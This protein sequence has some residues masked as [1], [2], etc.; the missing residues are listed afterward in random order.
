MDSDA[1]FYHLDLPFEWLM[2]YWGVDPKKHSLSLSYDPDF[3]HNRDEFDQLYLNTGF[4]INQNNE[5]T[6]EILK[7][8]DECTEEGGKHPDCKSFSFNEFGRPTDQG[9]FGTYIRYD[10]KN[11]IKTLPCSECN[12]FPE[13]GSECKGTFIRHMWSGKDTLIKMVTGHQFPGKFL[14]IIHEKFLGE[15]KDFYMSKA[16]LMAQS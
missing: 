6:M 12:G 13:D 15:K 3:P 10:Y 9:G 8:W 2:N 16:D 5:K 4:I 14:E 1:I 11:E 7:D